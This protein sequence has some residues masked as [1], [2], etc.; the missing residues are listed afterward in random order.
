[1]A[2]I[3]EVEVFCSNVVLNS[4]EVPG[5]PESEV[6]STDVWRPVKYMA[7]KTQEVVE[8]GET[9]PGYPDATHSFRQSLLLTLFDEETWDIV[10]PG[11]RYRLEL[12]SIDEDDETVGE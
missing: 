4:R 2:I 7:Y 3:A 11:Q 5:E 10:E 1:M 6:R 8:L 9:F 12:H